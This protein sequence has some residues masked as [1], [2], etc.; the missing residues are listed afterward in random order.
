LGRKL[1]GEKLSD[2]EKQILSR[3]RRMADLV[4]SYGKKAIL[5][6]LVYGIGPQTAAKILA[7]M[8][9]DDES[10]YRALLD[11]KLKFIVTRPYWD[12]S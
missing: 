2:S 6:M 8:H 10:F 4:L 9:E 7:E 12:R 11:A 5:A 1:K 3:G